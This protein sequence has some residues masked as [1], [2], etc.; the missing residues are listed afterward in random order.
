MS[1]RQK[2][3]LY[4]HLSTPY[5]P[6]IFFSWLLVSQL[7]TFIIDSSTISPTTML[8]YAAAIAAFAAAAAN[9]QQQGC[10]P[11]WRSGSA[12]SSGS[13]VSSNHETT[14]ADGSG[15]TTTTVVHNW[16]C[17]HGS[18]PLVSHC[19]TVSC[20]LRFQ[21]LCTSHVTLRTCPDEI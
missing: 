5:L 21:R 8:T 13:L 20:L 14:V 7:T 16:R 9:G 18:E 15:T 3:H 12:Y 11:K 17:T 6:I 19:S 4:T 10:Y 1:R 2:H